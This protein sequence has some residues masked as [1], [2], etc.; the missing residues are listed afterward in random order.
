[1]AE[2]PEFVR[3][4]FFTNTLVWVLV[5]AF[6][7]FAVFGLLNVLMG[8]IVENMMQATQDLKLEEELFGEEEKLSSLIQIRQLFHSLDSDNSGTLTEAEFVKAMGHENMAA[9]LD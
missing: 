5:A 2:Y 6:I 8:V 3:P 9:I 4:L 1:M 7:F